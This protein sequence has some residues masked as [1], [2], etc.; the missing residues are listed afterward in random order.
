MPIRGIATGT[1][2]LTGCGAFNSLIPKNTEDSSL[3]MVV[4][5]YKVKKTS[6][7]KIIISKAGKIPIFIGFDKKEGKTY[8]NT[9][10]Y[11]EKN[12]LKEIRFTANE[13]I[14]KESTQW[15]SFSL[16]TNNQ[17]EISHIAT[18]KPVY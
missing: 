9:N 14:D 15:G 13:K 12:N 2:S 7:N 10:T 8:K 11:I 18:C 1:I 6:N 5:S 3:P 4:L 16:A 17:D